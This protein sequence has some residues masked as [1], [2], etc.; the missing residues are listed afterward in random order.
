MVTRQLAAALLL[1]AGTA[2]RSAAQETQLFI[3]STVTRLHPELSYYDFGELRRRILDVRPDVIVLEVR[4][5]ELAERKETPGRPEYPAVVFPLL[6]EKRYATYPMEPGEPVFGEMVKS[7]ATLLQRFKET[8]PDAA[9]TLNA[10]EAA[11][12]AALRAC[13]HSPAAVNSPLTDRIIE[14]K[15][16]LQSAIMGPERATGWARWNDYM[17]DG[18]KRAVAENP[19]KRILA[20]VGY[21]N[22]YWLRTRLAN[23]SDARVID[24]YDALGGTE[25]WCTN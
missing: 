5:D 21:D 22:A 3:L 23:L 15:H 16:Q 24:M 2:T 8:Q 9:A 19:G 6:Q 13:W 25:K 17:V 1:I 11:A 14:A 18:V 20:L 10:Y 7:Y 4:P 12:V